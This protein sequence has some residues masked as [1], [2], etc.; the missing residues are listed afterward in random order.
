MGSKIKPWNGRQPSKK[1]KRIVPLRVGNDGVIPL[2]AGNE[3]VIPLRA[4]DAYHYQ[5]GRF[6]YPS[7]EED[8]EEY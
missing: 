7:C 6:L 4:G 8:T 3:G 1:G 5:E 2:R